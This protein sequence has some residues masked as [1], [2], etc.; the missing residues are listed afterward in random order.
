M[1]NNLMQLNEENME[2]I[3]TSAVFNIFT[4]NGGTTTF[5]INDKKITITGELH[6]F[7]G[8]TPSI[9]VGLN[10]RFIITPRSNFIKYKN[11]GLGI[12]GECMTNC[13]TGEE[14]K[15]LVEFIDKLHDR[16]EK[17]CDNLH[18]YIGDYAENI[19]TV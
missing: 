3:L 18:E 17:F 14:A 1:N 12:K 19:L 11:H 8:L 10:N 4:A 7:S 15:A 6:S 13:D 9:N 2:T 16:C 5:A